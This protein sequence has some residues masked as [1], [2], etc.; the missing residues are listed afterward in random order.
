[1]PKASASRQPGCCGGQVKTDRVEPLARKL[2]A[3]AHPV[4]LQ[5]LAL[6]GAA[7]RSVC[8]CELEAALP[9]KQPTVSHHLKLLRQ[10]GLIGSRQNGS[11]A[12]YFLRPDR[13][14][15]LWA[16]LSALA[17]EASGGSDGPRD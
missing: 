6:L 2:K 13:L 1:M 9:V 17:G 15:E 16:E 10:A 4:R 12:Y 14:A 3:L 5:I 7:G 8:V 11:W